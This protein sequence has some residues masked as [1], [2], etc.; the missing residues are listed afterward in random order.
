ML[1]FNEF[2]AEAASDVVIDVDAKRTIDNYRQLNTELDSLTS[3]PYQNA[4][5][6]LTQLRGCLERYGILIPATATRQFLELGSELVYMLTPNLSATQGIVGQAQTTGNGKPVSDM[7]ELHLYIVYD[8]N[9]DGYVDG[10]AQVVS[11]DELKSLL[12]MK[13]TDLLDREPIKL[14][15]STSYA[16]KEDDGGDTSEYA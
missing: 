13:P 7:P 9:D 6:L 11:E 2:L 3:R 10:Y 8:T 16:K 4:P 1:K 15:S 12:G 14:R 5:I